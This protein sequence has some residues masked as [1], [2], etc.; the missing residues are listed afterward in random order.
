[1][2]DPTR[3][4]T[5]DAANPDLSRLDRSSSEAAHDLFQLLKQAQPQLPPPPPPTR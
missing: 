4:E 2:P 1:M 3:D 5:F